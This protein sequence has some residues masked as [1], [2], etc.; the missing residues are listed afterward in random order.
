ME[1]LCKIIYCVEVCRHKIRINGRPLIAKFDLIYN[2]IMLKLKSTYTN[3]NA[4]KY[5]YLI[6]TKSTI[7]Y[8]LSK[9]LIVIHINDW[10][11]LIS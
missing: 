11:R 5:I 4:F 8:Y 9:M 3:Y 7:S 1:E 6:F 2:I 10:Y